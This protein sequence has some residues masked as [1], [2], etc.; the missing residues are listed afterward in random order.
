[1]NGEVA[2][3]FQLSAAGGVDP[4][5]Q[6][7]AVIETQRGEQKAR[8]AF[9]VARPET[10][11]APTRPGLPEQQRTPM[12]ETGSP[13][14]A[15]RRTATPAPTPRR[16]DA[17][18]DVIRRG[19]SAAAAAWRVGRGSRGKR[20]TA[21]DRNPNHRAVGRASGPRQ[22]STTSRSSGKPLAAQTP[23]RVPW[24]VRSSRREVGCPFTWRI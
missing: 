17:R 2:T 21:D 15:R 24:A 4:A 6:S 10:T 1:M 22:R 8:E 23:L 13:S 9:G 19:S 7:V 14:P 20:R 5:I 12:A 16:A 3:G 11:A 18:L